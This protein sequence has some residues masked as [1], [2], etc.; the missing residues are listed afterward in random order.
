MSAHSY[1]RSD[2]PC[3]RS[4]YR[5]VKCKAVYLLTST[6]GLILILHR[7]NAGTHL[8]ILHYQAGILFGILAIWHL[9]G[10]MKILQ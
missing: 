1:Y 9:C 4:W 6:T 2:Y 10:R 7:G 3:G 5:T 8:G